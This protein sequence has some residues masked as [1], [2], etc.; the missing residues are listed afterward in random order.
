MSP[1]LAL[2]WN[3]GTPPFVAALY[4]ANQT[5][6]VA[7]KTVSDSNVEFDSLNLKPGTYRFTV[8]DANGKTTTANFQVVDQTQIPALSKEAADA[9]NDPVFTQQMRSMVVAGYIKLQGR[10]WYLAA[11]QQIKDVPST[12][13]SPA[14]KLRESLTQGV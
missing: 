1:S 13:T 10:Q 9:L 11:Y 7:Q 5:D 6:P 12:D 2:P 3:G 8:K 4:A 14:G